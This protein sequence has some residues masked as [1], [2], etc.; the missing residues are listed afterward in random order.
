MIKTTYF[1]NIVKLSKWNFYSNKKISIQK[2]EKFKK[3]QYQKFNSTRQ[4]LSIE[5]KKWQILNISFDSFR[6]INIEDN[7]IT[8][9][10]YQISWCPSYYARSLLPIVDK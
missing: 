5:W 1:I 6:I 2:L 4:K 9:D 8:I 10:N 3:C 7:F